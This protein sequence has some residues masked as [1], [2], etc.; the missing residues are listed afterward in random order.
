ML[1]NNNRKTYDAVKS[2]DGKAYTGMTVGGKH[3]WKYDGGRWDETKI[4][5]DKWEFTFTCDKQ[6][7][8]HAPEGSGALPDT[9][10]HWYIIAD[11]KVIKVDED[12]Y[13]TAMAGVKFKVGHK[14]PQWK[15]WSYNYHGE[16][17]EDIAIKILEGIIEDL[18]ARKAKRGLDFFLKK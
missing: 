6:R 13:H 8:H 3:S 2:H 5:P 9:E 17:Y 7:L 11:Q 1:E 16:C 15:T 18:K 14:R 12:T 10:Y 4:S